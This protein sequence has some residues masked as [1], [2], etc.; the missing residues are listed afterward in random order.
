M[1]ELPV[2]LTFSGLD[3]TGGAGLQADIETIAALG[4]M[5]LPIMTTNT[6]QNTQT[7]LESQ[8]VD[9]AWLR[10]QARLLLQ[11]IT[12]DA[13][14]IGLAPSAETIETIADL[15][16]EDTPVVLD[17]ILRSGTGRN[18]ANDEHILAMKERLFPKCTIITP[19]RYEARTLGGKEVL[20]EAANQLIENGCRFVLITGADEADDRIENHLYGINGLI[21]VYLHEHLPGIFHGSGCTLS[22]AI[23]LLL[24]KGLNLRTAV[25]QALAYTEVALRS[26]HALGKKQ[27]HPRRVKTQ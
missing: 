27:N 7:F 15:I 18:L 22:S 5:A 21:E 16:P 4:G 12:P 17:P 20:D 9:P 8:G 6:I 19:N 14:K 24:A 23:A 26:G 2:V 1:N 11:D 10:R 13:I 25:E 3:P